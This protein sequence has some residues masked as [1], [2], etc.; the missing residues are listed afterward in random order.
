[1]LKIG[2]IGGSGLDDPDIIEDRKEKSVDTPFGRPSDLI[3]E[4]K[5]KGIPCA[6]LARHG[7]NHSILPSNVNYR[8]NVWALKSI[9]CTH[10]IVSTA[11]GNLIRKYFKTESILKQYPL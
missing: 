5:I 11:T 7:R 8:A 6:L 4:G 1:M 10:L 2:I 9:G 3:I